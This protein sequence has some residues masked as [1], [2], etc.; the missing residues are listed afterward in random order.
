MMYDFHGITNN[1]CFGDL[2]NDELASDLFFHLYILMMSERE[3]EREREGDRMHKIKDP[4]KEKACLIVSW[5]M[6]SSILL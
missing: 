1:N 5:S 4:N 3:R 6:S 2:P